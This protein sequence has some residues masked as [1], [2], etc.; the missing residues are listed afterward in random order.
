MLA[1]EALSTR[2]TPANNFFFVNHYGVPTID[3]EDWRLSITGLVAHEM[4]ISL[5]DLMAR[6]RRDMTWFDLPFHPES[7]V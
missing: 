4:S 5:A 3:P 2:L 6:P 7:Y 1:W